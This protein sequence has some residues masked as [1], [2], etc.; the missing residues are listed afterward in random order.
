LL[1]EKISMKGGGRPTEMCRA[2]NSWR[3][4]SAGKKIR[5]SLGGG[6]LQKEAAKKHAGL[7]YDELVK[8]GGLNV[9]PGGTR[10]AW[11]WFQN[12]HVQKKK[13]VALE[14]GKGRRDKQ[15]VSQFRKKRLR[16]KSKLECRNSKVPVQR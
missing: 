2:G 14:N 1:E 15:P 11:D 13:K 4:G 12:Q 16:E 9:K 5:K 6:R 8:R 3:E 7:A 10:G